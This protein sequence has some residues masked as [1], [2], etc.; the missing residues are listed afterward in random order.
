MVGIRPENLFDRSRQTDHPTAPISMRVALVETLGHE[1]L[2]HG[3]IGDPDDP[4]GP[5][6]PDG[7]DE[8]ENM[9][10]GKVD[11][12]HEPE[13]N[14]EIEMLARVDALHLYDPETELRLGEQG[15]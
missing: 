2:V 1:V 13:L 4:D 12:H 3:N 14:Q 7:S 5:D 11:P 9:L 15:E 6:A 10:V 8:P